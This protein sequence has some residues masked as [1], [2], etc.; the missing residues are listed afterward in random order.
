MDY[1]TTLGKRR[2]MKLIETKVSGGVRIN[3]FPITDNARRGTGMEIACDP[4]KEGV[5]IER[6]SEKVVTE[7]IKNGCIYPL[8]SPISYNDEVRKNLSR[9][10]IRFDVSSTYPELITNDIRNHGAA[11]P[12][13]TVA[14]PKETDYQYLDGFFQDE[15]NCTVYWNCYHAN[16]TNLN[17]D[18]IICNGHF[19]VTVKLPPVPRLTTYEIR[20][21][22]LPTFLRG[23]VQVYFG[24]DREN[25]YTPDI[26]LDMTHFISEYVGYEPDTGIDE[27]DADV[28]RA[29]RN[30]GIMKGSKSVVCSDG[31]ERSA[32]NR[33]LRRIVVREQMDP[34]KTYYLR[35]RSVLE[36]EMKQLQLD[37]LEFCP[38][39]VYDNPNQPE[40]I[41]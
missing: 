14:M 28:D 34:D 20:F 21:K 35:F 24:T 36:G 8:S 31:P 5:L 37:Y 41:W 33:D 18:E 19:D 22:L 23:I 3:R 32:Y 1:Y 12:G 25:L 27:Y 38:K 11:C 40:D 29:L 26:P 2:L 7:N 39:E 13:L 6:E 9:E 15:Q 16:F 17:D 10:R 30:Q 4:E